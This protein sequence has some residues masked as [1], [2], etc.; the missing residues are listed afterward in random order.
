MKKLTLIISFVSVLAIVNAQVDEKIILSND[1]VQ[2]NELKVTQEIEEMVVTK[3]KNE[4]IEY[5]Y[6]YG[7]KNKEQLENLRIGKPIPW[8]QI[9][10]EKLKPV[11][12]LSVNHLADGETLALKFSDRWLVPV[13]SA[14]EPLLFA[15]ISGKGYSYMGITPGIE[16]PIEYIHNYEHK[17]LII[18]SFEVNPSGNGMDFLIIRKEHKDIFVEVYDE[19]TGEYFKNEYSPG[20]LI[21]LLKDRAAKIK[22]AGSRYYAKIANKSEL[23]ITPEITKIVVNEAYSLRNS[24]DNTLAHYGIKNKVQLENV[25]PGKPIPKYR[26]INESLTFIGEWDVFVMSSGEPLF[27]TKVKLE[28]DGQYRYA[29][30]A[31]FMVEYIQNYEHK[32]LIIGSL[33][34]NPKS[35]WDYLIIRKDNKDIFVK[36]YDEVTRE[37]FKIEYTFNEIINLLKK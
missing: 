32:D 14:G 1:D 13:M 20:E 16:N 2:K 31:P 15:G 29:G 37:V 27:L 34:V 4:P 28:D 19:V 17:D 22:E 24:S 11:I 10:N 35:G 9:F 8:Y 12:A 3:I 23:E 26:I 25:Y 30:R 21:K 6:R 5:L 18:G 33:K 36:T 7:I